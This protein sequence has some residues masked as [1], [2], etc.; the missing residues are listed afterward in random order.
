[1]PERIR[2]EATRLLGFAVRHINASAR[3]PIDVPTLLDALVTHAVPAQYEHHLRA[4]YDEVEI[5][6][7]SDLA[8]SEAVTYAG[9]AAGARR[10]LPPGHETRE[11]LDERA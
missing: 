8:R 10:F 4:F 11:W 1:M 2:P 5:E 6:T 3:M 7:L 9:L